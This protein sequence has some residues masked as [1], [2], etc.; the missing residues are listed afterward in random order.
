[1]T[2]PV[3]RIVAT[4]TQPRYPVVIVEL[5]LP[6]IA[7][8]Q[9]DTLAINT[10]KVS[11]AT[12]SRSIADVQRVIPHVELPCVRRVYRRNDIRQSM[13]HG[14]DVFIRA[15]SIERRHLQTWQRFILDCQ[16]PARMRVPGDCALLLPPC[17]DRQALTRP[18]LD[19]FRAGIILVL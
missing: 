5:R 18:V 15:D 12:D 1:M 16:T 10:R 19:A 13:R 11:L 14:H 8:T 4:L 2:L 3:R 7:A 6:H 9:P 17:Q